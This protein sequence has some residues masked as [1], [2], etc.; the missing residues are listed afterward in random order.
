VR[1]KKRS[2]R[3]TPGKSGTKER[4]IKHLFLKVYF[5]ETLCHSGASSDAYSRV[6]FATTAT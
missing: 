4:L 1:I 6:I 5:E 3:R 2:A